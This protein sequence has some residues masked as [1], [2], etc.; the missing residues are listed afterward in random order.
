MFY[1]P[2]APHPWE[3]GASG[4]RQWFGLAGY[5]PI[6]MQRDPQLLAKRFN[7]MAASAAAAAPVLD[8]YI[9]QVL[10]HHSLEPRPASRC[11]GSPK[12]R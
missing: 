12:A 2:N 11:S 1:S 3:G 4:A 6:S 8:S 5:D 9:N 10:D 7:A